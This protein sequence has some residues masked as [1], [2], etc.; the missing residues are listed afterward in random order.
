MTQ[1]S[2][3]V[4][5]EKKCGVVDPVSLGHRW[6]LGVIENHA[7]SLSL[8][9]CIAGLG[10]CAWGVSP[11]LNEMIHLE[12]FPSDA[13]RWQVRHCI[14]SCSYTCSHITVVFGECG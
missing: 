9:L 3:R 11:G 4:R 5:V 12:S 10:V 6:M 7:L 8:F 14:F 1:H 13:F 2:M